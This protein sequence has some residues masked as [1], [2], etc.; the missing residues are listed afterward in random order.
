MAAPKSA[1]LGSNLRLSASQIH[2]WGSNLTSLSVTFYIC[3]MNIKAISIPMSI[4]REMQVEFLAN[5]FVIIL[6]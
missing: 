2:F 1:C 6:T 5:S 4:K 3:K